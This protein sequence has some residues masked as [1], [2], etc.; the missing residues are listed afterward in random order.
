MKRIEEFLKDYEEAKKEKIELILLEIHMP[1][2]E[3]EVIQN[4]NADAK[5]EYIKKAYDENLVHKNCKDIYIQGYLF[6]KKED[7]IESNEH[8]KL[9]SE[10]PSQS[11][12]KIINN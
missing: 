1:T 4:P 3:T 6:L 8:L 11:I 12:D 2:G 5:V 9:V 7:I 10:A